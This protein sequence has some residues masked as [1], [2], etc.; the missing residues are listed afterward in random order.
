M[1]G[2]KKYG[3]V[4]A[5]LTE[6]IENEVHQE[7]RYTVLGHT[8][9]GGTPISFDRILG[10]RFGSFAVKAAAAEKFGNMVTLKTPNLALTP[11]SNLAGLG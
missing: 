8:Q 7:V 11:L 2:V 10:T 6:K 9:R 3:G 1:Q 5:Y 4:G